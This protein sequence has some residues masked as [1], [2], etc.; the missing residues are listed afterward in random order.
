MQAT[1]R[2]PVD[3]LR[4]FQALVKQHNFRFKGNP[5]LS[6]SEAIVHVD[7]SHL[8]VHAWAPFWA[9]WERLTTP[10]VETRPTWIARMVMR[11]FGRDLLRM[12]RNK[13][14]L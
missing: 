9:D 7:A 4:Q 2:V 14:R 11:W 8:E 3:R 5:V 10:I 6:S 12:G 13:K 1:L